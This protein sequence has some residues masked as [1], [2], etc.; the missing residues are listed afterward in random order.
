MYFIIFYKDENEHLRTQQ[1]IANYLF[2]NYR[3]FENISIPTE[4]RVKS[5]LEYI[6][7]IR[8]PG[9]WYIFLIFEN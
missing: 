1:E 2:G 5:I 3:N 9:K 8:I 4:E 6:N 7:W